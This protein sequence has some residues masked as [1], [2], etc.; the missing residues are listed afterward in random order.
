MAG[1]IWTYM[2]SRPTPPPLP[3]IEAVLLPEAELR[4][5]LTQRECNWLQALEGD[6]DTGHFGFLHMGSVDV[7]QVDR[8]NMHSYSI[9]HRAPEFKV[10][11]TAWGAMAGAYRPGGPGELYWRICHFMFPFWALFPDGTFEDNVSADAWAP[12][13]DTHTMYFN[14]SWTRRTPPLRNTRDGETIPGLE[15]RHDYLPQTS[16]WFGRWRLAN[17]VENDYGIDREAQQTDSFTGVTGITLQDQYITESMGGVVDRTLEHLTHGD[18]MIV[19]TRQRLLQ[20]VRALG[21]TGEVPPGVDNPEVNL[22]ARSG[23]YL[24]AEGADW[25]EEYQQLLRNSISPGGR[26][27][28]AE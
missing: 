2:G 4:V 7:E 5:T 23:A 11:E 22:Q 12:M 20:A 16:D 17:S 6:L 28:A 21:E 1:V 27:K 14:F 15:F 9:S 24:G 10:V 26:L 8:G 3:A 18:A 13:D 19:K 25:L